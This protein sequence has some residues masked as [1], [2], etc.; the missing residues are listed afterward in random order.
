MEVAEIS[1]R[2]PG[3]V[4][5]YLTVAASVTNY[6]FNSDTTY[7]ISGPVNLDGTTVIEG[8]VVIKYAPTNTAKLS[9][10]GPLACQTGLYR[11]GVLTSKNDNSVGE[12]ISGSTGNPSNANGGTYI[13]G[14]AWQALTNAHLRFSFAGIGVANNAS[15][16]LSHC[17]FVI[18]QVAASHTDDGADVRMENV[19]SSRCGTLVAGWANLA[20]S[21][22][23]ADQT[24]RWFDQD[25]LPLSGRFTNCLITATTNAT[26]NRSLTFQN[27]VQ[28]SSNAGF[29][30]A[31]GGSQY[32]L[33]SASTN[34][35]AGSTNL[36]PN[37]LGDLRTRT[38]CAPTAY[39]NVT[40]SNAVTL[41]PQAQRDTD[42]PDLGYHYDPLDYTFGGCHAYSNLTVTAGT[43][44]GWFRTSSGWY[45]AGFGI[46]MGD[47]QIASF[48]GTAS[49]PC[50][51][52]R[53][54][55]VQERDTTAGY[56][57]GGLTGWA[58]QYGYDIT[59]SPEVRASYL[60]GSM[61][62]SEGSHFRDDW[63]YLIVRA[64]HSQFYNGAIGAYVS[65]FYLT[66]CLF[67]R[68][69][70][71]QIEGWPGNEVVMKNCT[72]IGHWVDFSAHTYPT[73]FI[74]KDNAFD[75][76]QFNLTG[77]GANASYAT[78][79]YNAYTNATKPFPVGGANDKTNVVFN[80][81]RGPLGDWYLPTNSVLIDAG[82]QSAAAAG[83]YH[84]TTTTNQVKDSSTVDIGVHYVAVDGT[85]LPVDTDG[86]GLPD[87][88]EDVN[89]NGTADGGEASWLT[90]PNGTTGQSGLQVYT[91]LK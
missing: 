77:Y 21:H 61:S 35:N 47:R 81:Q 58:S 11:P 7:Y 41:Y 33:V 49:A 3:V 46:H 66:N 55:T 24:G 9:L 84:H 13:E 79:D 27:T 19:L 54:T 29:Y 65:S 80:W 56:G 85:G 86:D 22:L 26:V 50:Y 76:V 10:S 1:R 25:Y 57:P 32:Y 20:A 42:A 69:W 64:S 89:G 71:G 14:T 73:Y 37:L 60:V 67:H 28:S 5:D 39:T 36:S 6:V 91:P 16:Q 17:Q 72:K 75:G 90:S 63:G 2:P 74:V 43:A 59:L 34:R 87:Y 38:T 15:L 45:H 18:C 8:G 53:L 68:M 83:L 70:L 44:L 23:T 88:W 40:F 12:T 30:Q 51:W 52:V 62:A 78:Y 82:S 48:E 4:I 31:V